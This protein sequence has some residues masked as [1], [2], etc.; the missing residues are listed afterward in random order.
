MMEEITPIES[1]CILV[2]TIEQNSGFCYGCGRT[3]DEIAQWSRITPAERSTLM[4]ILP[5]R[6]AGLTRKPR[7][8]TKRRERAERLG[9]SE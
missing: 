5:A 9:I 6:V 1:P 2:C 7:R 8:K 3:S 4:A